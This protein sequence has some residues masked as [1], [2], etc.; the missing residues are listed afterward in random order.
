M[1]NTSIPMRRPSIALFILLTSMI[2]LQLSS[3]KKYDHHD[4]PNKPQTLNA[5]VIDKWMN[6]QMRLMRN[7]TG[8]P[9][10][11][12][13]RHFA[14]A[15]VTA[16]EA[17]GPGLSGHAYWSK[18]WNGLTG[19]PVG[20]QIKKR[21]YPASINAAMASINRLMF[22][23]ANAIDKA[24]IDSLELVLL[25]S[26]KSKEPEPVIIQSINFGKAVAAAV[27]NW[28]ETDGYKNAGNP[29]V[30]PVGPG[31]WVP[32]P[33]A[34]SSAAT[35]YWGANRTIISGSIDGTLQPAPP[36]Y[37]TH[38][39]SPFYQMVKQ[40]YDVSQA[41]TD[42]QKAM[43]LFWRDVPGATSPGHW[44]SIVQ[45][46]LRKKSVSLEK[47][48]L[49]YALTGIVIN[50]GLISCFKAK[51]QHNLVRPV[52]YIRDVMGHGT[53]TSFLGTPAHPEYLS[54]HASLS[55]GAAAVLE[56]L[57]GSIG[58][59]TDHTYDYLGFV[60]RT[61]NSFAA[62][63]EEAAHSRLYAGIHYMPGIVNGLAQ[64]RKVAANI[65]SA[66]NVKN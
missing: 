59:F 3:C 29:Y 64:G 23:N 35:P 46:V 45:Q 16:V 36:A 48:V 18:K 40:V 65:F 6:L 9:N 33:P 7:A 53:W 22:P 11:G 25:E 14:Y 60:P 28:S 41:L 17:I 15:G 61:Y 57:F 19:L 30:P 26:Y 50:D 62:I 49:A 44:L 4:H 34:F 27:F 32:T 1:T 52:T 42:D 47:A 20:N 21:Y 24:A 2:L 66:G 13:A 43:A 58:T 51:Y 38:P 56:K 31:L 55:G 12:F 10:H 54:A 63:G 37:S 5:D 8:I 39:A